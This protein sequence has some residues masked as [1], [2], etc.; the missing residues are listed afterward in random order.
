MRVVVIGATGLIGSR[1]VAG[2]RDH[3]VDV[4]PVSRAD[5]VD[6]TT[7]EGLGRALGGAEVVVDATDSPSHVEAASV[8]FFNTATR[9]L[10]RAAMAAGA[11]H[12]VMLSVVGA[13]HAPTGYFRAKVLQEELVRRS[14]MPHSIVRAAPLFES[15]DADCRSVL[16]GGSVHVTPAWVRPVSADDVAG[17]VARTVVGGPRFGA[18]EV[19]GPEEYRLDDLSARLLAARGDVREVITDPAAL[20]LGVPLLLWTLLPESG[21][22]VTDETV[23]QWLARRKQSADA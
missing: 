6:V 9:N 23:A 1:I 12:Y 15:V 22:Q 13:T 10:L 5:G 16:G 21:A 2:L 3:G 17:T 18:L 4:V 7:G 14:P 8:D 20:F 19:V 11:E